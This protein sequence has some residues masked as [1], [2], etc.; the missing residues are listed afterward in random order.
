MFL[1]LQPITLREANR[2]VLDHHR[3]HGPVHG[4]VRGCLFCVAINNGSEV[5]GVAIVGRP[6][7][8][9]LQDGYTAEVLRVCVLP[10]NRNA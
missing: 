3:H 1:E 10:G 5:I 6:V 2:F 9:M 8:R 4:P 7:S